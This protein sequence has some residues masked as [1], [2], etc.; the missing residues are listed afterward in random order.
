MVGR[1]RRRGPLR[2]TSGLAEKYKQKEALEE[3]PLSIRDINPEPFN[4]V[5]TTGKFYFANGRVEYDSVNL[6]T[7][8]YDPSMS[9]PPFVFRIFDNTYGVIFSGWGSRVK[10]RVASLPILGSLKVSHGE[11]CIQ[12]VMRFLDDNDI[13][14]SL[15]THVKF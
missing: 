13:L 7:I 3:F 12:K 4:E 15:L 1:N 2:S 11:D 9:G 14:K 6:G 5:I 10:E 8:R